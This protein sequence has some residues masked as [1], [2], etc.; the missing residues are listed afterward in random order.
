M[1][2]KNIPV[3]CLNDGKYKTETADA[4]VSLDTF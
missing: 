4:K 2:K 1:R 3:S